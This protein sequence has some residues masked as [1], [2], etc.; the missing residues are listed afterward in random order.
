MSYIKVSPCFANMTNMDNAK[1]LKKLKDMF[2]VLNNQNRIRIIILCSNKP[3]T[4]TQL[5]KLL[6]LNYSVTSDYI[7][8]LEKV[9]LIA[10]TRNANKTVSVRALVAMNEKGELKRI[11]S[12]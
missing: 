12:R 9:G 1:T 5:S 4:V 7:S 2:A 8:M 3:H 6:R 11:L 10:K